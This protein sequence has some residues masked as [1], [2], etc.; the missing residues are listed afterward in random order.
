MGFMLIPSDFPVWLKW[1]YNVGMH[2]YAWRTFMYT[3]FCCE[4]Q[5]Y[6]EDIEDPVFAT[7]LDVLEFYEIDDV[8]RGN[9]VSFVASSLSVS[10]KPF[11]V[12]CNL[13][14]TVPY[15]L[16][17]QLIVLACYALIIHIMSCFVLHFKYT[18][19]RGKIH[20]PAKSSTVEEE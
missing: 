5:L 7:G 4:D 13:T 12:H 3:E 20:P 17:N 6:D 19:F 11:L 9:D 16:P 10:C 15:Y 2:T 14:F 18:M 8:N 1:T